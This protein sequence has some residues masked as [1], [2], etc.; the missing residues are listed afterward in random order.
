MLEKLKKR[1][2][3]ETNPSEK[4]LNASN[5]KHKLLETFEK[6]VS[7]EPAKKQISVSSFFDKTFKKEEVN[8]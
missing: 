4:Q 3:L 8:S 5:N 2:N 1:N 6:E 7:L